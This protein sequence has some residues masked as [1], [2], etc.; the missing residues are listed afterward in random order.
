MP[1]TPAANR[2]GSAIAAAAAAATTQPRASTKA[3]ASAKTARKIGA[4][5][6]NPAKARRIPQAQRVQATQQKIIDSALHLLHTEGFKGATLQAI[7]R[8][9]QVSLG[10]LQHHFDNRDMLMQRLVEEVMQPLSDQ[11]SVWPSP[12]L[13]LSERAQAFVQRAWAQIFGQPHYQAAW[14]LFFGS[15]ASPALFASIDKHRSAVDEVFYAQFLAVFPE[16]AAHHP[17]PLGFAIQVF[18]SLRGAGVLEVFA[19]QS[20]ERQG[21]LDALAHSIAQAAQ[22]AAYQ[23]PTTPTNAT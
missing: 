21:L 7:A 4:K 15:K 17:H 19:V 11:G 14:S 13:A 3:P 22:P 20:A 6:T 12:S 1:H 23:P 8:G 2:T 9:A 5:A 10:A 18:A 16:I